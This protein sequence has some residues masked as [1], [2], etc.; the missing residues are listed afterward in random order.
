MN[1][2]DIIRRLRY[3]LNLSDSALITCFSAS[4]AEVAP[5]R[6]TALLKREDE[7]GFLL[8]SDELLGAFLDGL[9]ERYRGK[10]ADAPVAAGP[11]LGMTNNRVLRSLKIA[12]ELKDT[13]MIELMRLAGFPVSKGQLSALFRREGHPNY[14]PCGDQFLRNFLRGLTIHRRGASP[15]SP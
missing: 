6:L 3:A 9:V 4:S 12:L 10:R 5:A 8:M 13:D 1:N 11:T 14:Q 15:E 7:P 2:N